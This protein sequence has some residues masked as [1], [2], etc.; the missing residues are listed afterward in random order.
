MNLRGIG[1]KGII[2]AAAVFLLILSTAAA[3]AAI[4]TERIPT[5]STVVSADTRFKTGLSNAEW[6]INPAYRS[7]VTY[8]GG[9]FYLPRNRTGAGRTYTDLITVK[10]SDAGI[11]NGRSVNVE[12]NIDRLVQTKELDSRTTDKGEFL[13]LWS[14]ETSL[15]S[16]KTSG[17]AYKCTHTI[18]VSYR[19]TY[20]DTGELVEMPFFQAV[21][22]VDTK[23][24][25]AGVA[26]GFKAVSG[27][28]KYYTYPACVLVRSGDGF[29]SPSQLETSGRDSWTKTGFYATTKNGEFKSTHYLTNCRTEIYIFNQYSQN[30]IDRPSL[31]VDSSRSYREGEEIVWD[32][33]QR[34][35]KFFETVMSAYGSFSISDD[36]PEGVSYRSA[37]ALDE[38]GRDVT[39]KGSLRYDSSQR[40]V[41]FTFKD[42][43]LADKNNYDGSVY[44]LRIVTEA[45][46][47]EGTGMTVT[48]VAQS[49]ISSVSMETNEQSVRIVAP[50]LSVQKTNTGKEYYTGERAGYV[51]TFGQSTEGALAEEAALSDTLPEGLSLDRD[52]IVI[53]GLQRDDYRL[54]INEKGFTVH[55][56]SMEYG[57][58][59]L[60][61]E[62]EIRADDVDQT[63]TNTA[64]ITASNADPRRHTSDLTVLEIPKFMAGYRFV[65]G[66]DTPLPQDIIDALPEDKREY[67]S[68]SEV[69]AIAPEAE[70]VDVGT[71]LWTFEGYDMEKIIIENENVLF[72]GTWTYRE[73]PAVL[74]VDKKA[75][76]GVYYDGDEIRYTIDFRQELQGID[77]E[78]VV[79]KD[80]LP[81]GLILDEESISVTGLAED[82]YS[83]RTGADRFSMS[84]P[85]LDFGEYR[86]EYTARADTGK[87]EASLTNIVSISA[88]N[89]REPASSD[90]TVNIEGQFEA[91]YDFV[92]DDGSG[93]PDEI[94][95][96]IPKDGSWYR[97]GDEVT[98]KKPEKTGVV[99][100]EGRWDFKG[101]DADT[102]R[103]E[104]R[105]IS[106]TGTWSLDRPAF[107]IEKDHDRTI[108]YYAGDKAEYRIDFSQDTKGA[109]GL[110]VRIT[111]I[112]PEG[113]ALDE[114]SIRLEGAREYTVKAS[115]QGFEV[116][117]DRLE[118][119]KYALLYSC[120]ITAE[121]RERTF[122]N[123]ASITGENSH[124]KKTVR[125]E[126]TVLEIPKRVK[127]E[128]YSDDGSILPPEVLALLP[129]DPDIYYR[130][131]SVKA[132]EPEAG[133]VK[134]PGK[135]WRFEGYDEEMKNVKDEDV[136]FSG[137]WTKVLDITAKTGDD[138]LVYGFFG[139]LMALA[140][141]SGA[142]A[143]GR[144]K[145]IGR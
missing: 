34:I 117:V 32:V 95:K 103:V 139:T 77:A 99:T 2:A 135:T 98:A 66:D 83:L 120:E 56:K 27:Y 129:E 28:T 75:A 87:N 43:F 51:I 58:Y 13:K 7:A 84:I 110:G 72:T 3:T 19:I 100:D 141:V 79:V 126:L 105:D 142:L 68:G 104:G 30:L 45:D 11:I 93:L 136:T 90:E 73:Y 130:G 101:Y 118:Y 80:E 108:P 131:D 37:K 36:I 60:E 145:G 6:E 40:R 76:A 128:F 133:S 41:V 29:Y 15:S 82:R 134:V 35:G 111:D 132:A 138:I 121:D 115:E 88:D 71:G 114:D 97:E 31:E 64:V 23:Q 123:E 22:D 8:S 137:R 4:N 62:A 109:Y 91:D 67:V 70:N 92:S 21:I 24:N 50:E 122:T 74:S 18:D 59:R 81:E 125:D 5:N 16:Y 86:I 65:S 53:S 46:E 42:S 116:T 26:E 20:A 55:M 102:K 107:S 69:T 25:V 39:D 9:S 17:G 38:K 144:R 106:F 10:Y 124:V 12:M 140:A 1:R 113:Y 54:E 94:E 119:G 57:E 112:L 33:K 49:E 143:A 14:T 44:T 96:L 89:G 52:S 127:Y 85:S 47:I 48:D 78:N 61:Y 63:L